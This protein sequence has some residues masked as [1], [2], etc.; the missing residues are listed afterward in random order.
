ME[1]NIE[2]LKLARFKHGLTQKDV[3]YKLGIKPSTYSGYELGTRQMTLRRAKE[4]ADLL[5]ISI[6]DFFY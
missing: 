4:I 1:I 5:E 3:A 6:L 2:I